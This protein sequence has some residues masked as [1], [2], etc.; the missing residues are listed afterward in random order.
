M[1]AGSFFIR[2]GI[3]RMPVGAW[4]AEHPGRS[5]K[6]EAIFIAVLAEAKEEVIDCRLKFG[7]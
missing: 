3:R 6:K 2:K 1:R 7:N 4:K 5:G